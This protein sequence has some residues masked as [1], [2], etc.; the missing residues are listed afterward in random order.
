LGKTADV[1][2]ARLEQVAAELQAAAA[3]AGHTLHHAPSVSGAMMV[4]A[5]PFMT[6]EV[7]GRGP[8]EHA[9]QRT[10]LSFQRN[11]LLMTKLHQPRPR[12][13]LVS[14]SHLVERLQ[15]GMEHALTLIS[16]PTGFG[17]TT[18]LAQ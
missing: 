11:P 2:L 18:L 7:A 13:R 5:S 12:H 15:Q 8:T 10:E 9:P 16:A 4:K 3:G 1:T 14:R 17:K 6:L